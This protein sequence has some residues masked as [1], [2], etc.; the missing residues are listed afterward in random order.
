MV[1]F[2]GVE[3]TS[4]R[5]LAEHYGVPHGTYVNRQKRGWTIAQCLGVEKKVTIRKDHRPITVNDKVYPS[6]SKAAKA[7]NLAPNLC[8]DRLD[9][10]WSID[11]VFG[12]T[13]NPERKAYKKVIEVGGAAFSSIRE[14]AREHDEPFTT[15]LN[16]ISD[17]G[18]YIPPEER[19]PQKRLYGHLIP[20]IYQGR[21]YPSVKS[22]LESCCIC[23][24]KI[25]NADEKLYR[26]LK[27]NSLKVSIEDLAKKADIKKPK[28]FSQFDRFIVDVSKVICLEDTLFDAT[29][30]MFDYF[31]D[32]G[33]SLKQYIEHYDL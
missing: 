33:F 15:F 30:L 1:L 17:E 18:R 29:E 6:I 27:R 21:L 19:V 7:Y 9:L 5:K 23:E 12:L 31:E 22:A 20:F 3:F 16:N 32:A 24:R 4:H 13:D 14:A 8:R 26:Y 25:K 11:E 2:D 28:L 10:G